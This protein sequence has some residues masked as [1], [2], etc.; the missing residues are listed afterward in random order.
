MFIIIATGL[1]TYVTNAFASINIT[2]PVY[3][4]GMLVALVIRNIAT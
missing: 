3:I 1:G 4:G 2:L